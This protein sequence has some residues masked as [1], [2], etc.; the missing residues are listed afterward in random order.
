MSLMGVAMKTLI[1]TSFRR[2]GKTRDELEIPQKRNDERSLYLAILLGVLCFVA[3]PFAAAVFFP[4]TTIVVVVVLVGWFCIE[5]FRFRRLLNQPAAV[6]IPLKC[7]ACGCEDLNDLSCGLWDGRDES[8]KSISG[9]FHYAI[10][11]GCGS[12][13]VQYEDGKPRVPTE[14]EWDAHF[15]PMKECQD[16]VGE[17]PFIS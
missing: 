5:H 10:C 8:G 2:L 7:A 3:V 11:K 13:C 6:S 16:R 9:A 17:W 14:E 1:P 15:R 12:R 4:R